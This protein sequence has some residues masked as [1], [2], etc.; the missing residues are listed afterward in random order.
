MARSSTHWPTCGKQVADRDAALAVVAELPRAAE[1]VSHVVE[2]RRM[3]LDLDRL[4]MLAVEPRLGVE[5]VDLRRPAVH[6]QEDDARGLCREVRRPCRQRVARNRAGVRGRATVTRGGAEGR[7]AKQRR[8]GQRA[9]A[10]ATSQQH[11]AA[12]NRGF[13]ESAAVHGE[14]RQRRPK[15]AAGYEQLIRRI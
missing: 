13:D 3:R 5:R 15:S 7:L 10:P 8:Q 12:A 9:E 11:V 2:L 1:H 14:T 6:E 4:P